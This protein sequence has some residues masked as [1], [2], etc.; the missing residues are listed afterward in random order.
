MN[1]VN[2]KIFKHFQNNC[3]SFQLISYDT[4][5]I[6]YSQL[7]KKLKQENSRQVLFN[8]EVMMLLVKM[9]GLKLQSGPLAKI[10]S[11]N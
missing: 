3:Y 6:S 4:N 10:P 1:A 11:T 8:S 7:I 2:K 5:K 9:G